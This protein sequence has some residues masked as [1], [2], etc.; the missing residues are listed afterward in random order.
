SRATDAPHAAFHARAQQTLQRPTTAK[1]RGRSERGDFVPSPNPVTQPIAM[2]P[3]QASGVAPWAVAASQYRGPKRTQISSNL[4][5]RL[6]ARCP[7]TARLGR[8]RLPDWGIGHGTRISAAWESR[9]H[10]SIATSGR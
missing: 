2:Q 4:C 9:A 6:N 5:L 8:V 1:P 7:W 3:A 10:R